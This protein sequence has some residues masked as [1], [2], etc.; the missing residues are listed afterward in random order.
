MFS[1]EYFDTNWARS[2]YDLCACKF[3]CCWSLFSVFFF[4][5][6]SF[7]FLPRNIHVKTKGLLKFVVIVPW[8]C[9]RETENERQNKTE[10]LCS[11]ECVSVFPVDEVR[12]QNAQ[13]TGSCTAVTIAAVALKSDASAGRIVGEWEHSV[14]LIGEGNVQFSRSEIGRYRTTNRECITLVSARSVRTII[15]R[16][17]PESRLL[18]YS[19]TDSPLN[20]HTRY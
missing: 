19:R 13:R 1:S 12:I 2:G 10:T 15:S 8:R 6:V 9:A 11:G 14:Y 3:V 16:L 18:N 20:C 7:P 17:A 4:F 5:L